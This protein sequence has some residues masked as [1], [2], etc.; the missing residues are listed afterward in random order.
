MK[1]NII[2]SIIVAVLIAGCNDSKSKSDEKV[3]KQESTPVVKQEVKKVEPVVKTVVKEEKGE[4]KKPQ[5]KEQR[6]ANPA[7]GQK[8]FARK[9]K[10][11]CGMNGGEV[12]K[13]HTQDEWSAIEK[14][15]KIKEEIK[16]ICPKAS[17]DALKDKYLENYFDFFY[18]FASDSGNIPSC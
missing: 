2:L 18:N 16:K 10:E 5:Q 14:A 15:G 1:K 8:I 3:S 17:D 4:I 11:A 12:A 7:K 6:R 13:K 9:L